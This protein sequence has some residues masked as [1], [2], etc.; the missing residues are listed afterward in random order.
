MYVCPAAAAVPDT[1]QTQCYDAAGVVLDPCPPYG[2]SLYGQDGFYSINP[3]AYT[4]LDDGG[5]ALPDNATAWFMVRDD[6]TGLVWENKQTAPNSA[7]N[8]AD[9][10]DP[11]NTYTWYD[12]ATGTPRI[13]NDTQ[14]FIAALNAEQYGGYDDWRLPTPFELVAIADYG[15]MSPAINTAFFA[16][17]KNELYWSDTTYVANT[18]QAF[19]ISF[20]D[21]VPQYRDK[22]SAYFVRAVRGDKAA[23]S[24]VDNGDGTV[25]DT[26][27]GLMWQQD[28]STTSRTWATALD[29]CNALVLGGYTDWRSPNIKEL[30]SLMDYSHSSP[31]VTPGFFT[32]LAGSPL[33]STSNHQFTGY[34]YN[35]YLSEGGCNWFMK[36]TTGRAWAVRSEWPGFSIPAC[37][38]TPEIIN[39]GME[40]TIACPAALDAGSTTEY[41]W[42]FDADGTVDNITTGGSITIPCPTMGDVA[43]KVVA[44]DTEHRNAWRR[45]ELRVV[46]CVDADGDDYGDNCS[47]GPDCDDTNSAV[48]PGAVETCNGLDDDCDNQTDEGVALTFYRDSD[49]DGYGDAAVS[50]QACTAPDGYVADGTDCDD[51][52]PSAHE[53]CSDCALTLQP[54]SISRLASLFFPIR[55]IVVSAQDGAVFPQNPAVAWDTAALENLLVK[56]RDDATLHVWVRIR[57]RLLEPGKTCTV[58][59]GDCTGGLG[60]RGA[61]K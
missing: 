57:P 43:G 9:P 28:L 26:A 34:S 12:G 40:A 32:G 39:P 45:F 1:G 36:S 17:T 59:V 51:S 3:P 38:V 58:T 60:V 27:T 52:D 6:V 44:E 41:L 37:T 10:H 14:D 16:N 49:A 13:D 50:T 21:G 22:S 42:D 25:T 11:D 19:S 23:R 4:K 2:D 29:Y 56:R 61:S 5:A 31:A 54:S 46:D 18:A 55:R 20:F 15:R 48:F 53:N 47:A 33:S 8:Y 35:L 24:L 7:K 30:L